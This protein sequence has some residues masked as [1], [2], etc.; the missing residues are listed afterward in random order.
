MR[1]V[2]SAIIAYIGSRAVF[3][4]F[5]FSYDVFR[6]PLNVGDLLIDFGVFVALFMGCHWLLGLRR[7]QATDDVG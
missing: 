3:A 1:S 4:A 5:D 7:G 6:E 2:L